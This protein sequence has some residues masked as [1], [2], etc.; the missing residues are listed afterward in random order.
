MD[1]SILVPGHGPVGNHESIVPQRKYL[2]ALID[3]VKAGIRRGQSAD[4]I[5]ETLDL[6]SFHP[7]GEDVARNQVSIRAVYAKLNK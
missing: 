3:G 1:V 4:A 2:A 6:T 5:A 7:N